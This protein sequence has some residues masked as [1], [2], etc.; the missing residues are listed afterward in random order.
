M[1][2]VGLDNINHTYSN[3]DSYAANVTVTSI[4]SGKSDTEVSIN[5]E[6]VFLLSFS[7]ICFFAV[8]SKC[9]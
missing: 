8:I 3:P 6:T 5:L 1:S 9:F 4:L 2:G 7:F